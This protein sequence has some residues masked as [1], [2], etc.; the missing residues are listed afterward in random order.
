MEQ[1]DCECLIGSNCL[2]SGNLKKLLIRFIE[3]SKMKRK[4]ISIVLFALVLITLM[5]PMASAAVYSSDYIVSSKVEISKASSGTVKV[6]FT[7]TGKIGVNE[8]GAKK[9]VIYE[10]PNDSAWTPKK[11]FYSNTTQA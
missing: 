1:E 3:G 8:A 5:A 10:S 9:V 11:T 6:S 4:V 2:V 7:V